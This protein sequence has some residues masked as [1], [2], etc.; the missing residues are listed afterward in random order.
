MLRELMAGALALALAVFGVA[1]SLAATATTTVALSQT[2]YTDLG[3][4][5]MLLGANGGAVIYQVADSQ[6]A[7]PTAGLL[8]QS[9]DPPVFVQTSSH[10]WAIAS[11]PNNINAIV[12]LGTGITVGGGSGGA[13]TQATSPWVVGGLGTAGA[14]SGGV[15]SVQGVAGG[16]AQPVSN[17]SLPLPA[18][19]STSA[20]QTSVQS[21]PGTPQTTA[22]TVQGNASNVA[23]PVSGTFWQAT[24][25]VSNA[26]L[27]LPAGASTAAKQPALGTAGTA[28]ADVLSIQGVASM[29]AIKTDGSAV[30]QPVSAASLPLPTGAS[31]SA[32]QS[33]VIGTIGAGTAAANSLAIG[34]VFNS[35][36]PTL[37]NGQQA[38]VQLDASGRQ[39][40]T[41]APYAYTPLTPG[42]HN[43]AIVTSTALTVP[44][45]STYAT[46]CEATANA[47]YTTDGT[48]TPTSTI[49]M[50]LT[51][52]ACVTLSGAIVVANFKAISATGT[53]DVE[54][55]R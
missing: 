18:G 43:L 34:G 4:G 6:P 44:T 7:T 46:V 38:A 51:T 11:G 35:T 32:I 22:L 30:T 27:P 26:S 36:L 49:G 42:Q 28:S 31:T 55:F 33:S 48:T 21:A 20:N 19:A 45:G 13:V 3:A 12:S 47:K 9:G 15:V 37:T 2:A 24:Q 10:V 23:L 39:I 25:P 50:T 5:P 8:Q 16:I 52:G 17:A 41:V 1:P 54:Y 29:T 53:L 14:P 40:V